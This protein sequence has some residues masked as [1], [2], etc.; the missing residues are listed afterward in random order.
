MIFMPF[1]IRFVWGMAALLASLWYPQWDITWAL[2]DK[3][4]PATAFVYDLTGLLILVGLIWAFVRDR[5]ERHGRPADLSRQDRPTLLLIGLLVLA[6]FILE[7][8][9]IAMTGTPPGSEWA[10]AGYLLSALFS[11]GATLTA[12]YGYLWYL[13]AILGGAFIAYL[14]FSRLLHIILAP[15]VLGMQ[16]VAGPEHKGDAHN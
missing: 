10:F 11:P 14:P 5:S 4:H 9:R 7:G 12:F 16:A 1:V 15:I 8:A 3:N 13:H 6:G 2:L